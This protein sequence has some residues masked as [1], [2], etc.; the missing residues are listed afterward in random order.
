[1]GDIWKPGCEVRF[2]PIGWKHWR[3]LTREVTK[4]ELRSGQFLL[5][6][7]G[8]RDRGSRTATQ[9]TCVQ[10][11]RRGITRSEGSGRR[12]GEGGNKGRRCFTGSWWLKYVWNPHIGTSDWLCEPNW[13]C[14]DSQRNEHSQPN[15]HL[16][17]VCCI[18]VPMNC[19]GFWAHK[20]E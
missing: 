8:W 19:A 1:M 11:H 5:N 20:D 12:R 9:R 17:S 14:H 4:P 16:L 7:H 13:R 2:Y 15:K 10:E 6:T 18:E 3:F